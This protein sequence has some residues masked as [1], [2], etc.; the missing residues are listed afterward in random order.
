MRQA[1][2]LS[3]VAALAGCSVDEPGTE[4][5]TGEPPA[6]PAADVCASG[7]GQ[8]LHVPSP[9]WRDQ[10]IYMLMIDRFNDG[11]PTNNDQ[12]YGEYDPARASHFSGGDLQGVIDRLEYIRSLGATAVWITPPVYNQWWSTPYQATGWHGYWAVHFQQLD[13]HF[14]ALET[15]KRLSHELHCRGMYLIQDIVANHVGNFFAYD[16]EYDPQD[17]ARNF[18]LLEPDSH[19]P[20]PTQY[21]FNLID[22]LNPEHFAADI[23]HWT[24]PVQD[25]SDP[26]QEHYYSLGHVNDINTENPRV[27]AAFKEIYKYWIDEVGVDA[28]RMDTVMLVP[29]QFWNRFLHD[30]DGIYAHARLR[31]KEH[32]LTF[33]E[34]TAAS[35]PY[36]DFGERKVAAYLETD[37]VQGPNSML[38]YPLYH[39]ISRVLARGAETASLAYRLER[40][41]DLYPDPKVIPNFV[42]NHDTARFLAAGHAAAFRQALAVI[43]TIPGIPIVY[44]GT[45]QGLEESRMAMFAGGHRKPRRILR[46][47]F[48]LLPLSAAVD[49]AA[50]RTCSTDAWR[51][52][53]PGLRAQRAGRA[54]LPA[55]VRGRCRDRADEQRRSQHPGASARR[56]R[57]T[58]AAPGGPV[59]RA[60]DRPTGHRR[61]G[62]VELAAAAE[63]NRCVAARRRNRVI[64]H[65][66]G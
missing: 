54:G 55:R 50:R 44:Q 48:G 61:G 42:D 62:P 65:G 5:G 60:A 23:Y 20:A 16:G 47:E 1:V 29:L 38:G 41:M 21:P 22:R 25:F 39:E 6:M 57:R 49:L 27:I 34:V 13:P 66:A 26:Y 63:G 14:G 33:G 4:P 32:F 53:T 11:D 10:V 35:E 56:G 52:S 59:Q 58:V 64:G 46:H 3:V 43:F 8:L 24:P 28:F 37:G 30:D 31:G 36:D 40:F 18:Y 51:P 15:Y 19:Q 7:D 2:L 12:G 45:E 9:D 17:T